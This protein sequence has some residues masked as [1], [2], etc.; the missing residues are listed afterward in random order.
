MLTNSEV[1]KHETRNKNKLFLSTSL[2]NISTEQNDMEFYNSSL[3][4]KRNNFK[5][6]NTEDDKKI[7]I[8]KQYFTVY[9]QSFVTW[10][11]LLA[12]NKIM[13]TLIYPNYFY[14]II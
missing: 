14:F 12:R 13:F 7:L 4:Y 9:K 1:H 11:Y 10:T 2:H 6:T 5:S 3:L 8:K